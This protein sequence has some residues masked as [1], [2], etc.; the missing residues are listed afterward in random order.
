MRK[1]ITIIAL[2]LYTS[3][4]SINLY[5][6]AI[7]TSS[8]TNHTKI[9]VAVFNSDGSPINNATVCVIDDRTYTK[10]NSNGLTDP[11]TINVPEYDD[12]NRQTI[13]LLAYKNGYASHIRYNVSVYKNQTKTG[14]ILET[15]EILN[16][17]DPSVITSYEQN[18]KYLEDKIIKQYKRGSF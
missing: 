11:I 2:L 14:I 16:Q 12:N 17:S 7:N 18:P 10:T 6:I 15:Y 3:L 4:L 13:T 8:F 9:V 1:F 5:E